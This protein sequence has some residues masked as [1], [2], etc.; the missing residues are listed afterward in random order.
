[1]TAVA[2]ARQAM[3]AAARFGFAGPGC[4][5]RRQGASP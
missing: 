3:A 5:Q 4:G 1:L 2:E